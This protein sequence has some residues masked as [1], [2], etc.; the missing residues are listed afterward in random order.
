MRTSF[1]GL[2]GVAASWELLL[3]LGSLY[4][5]DDSAPGHGGLVENIVIAAHKPGTD[6]VIA[7][8]F[9]AHDIH[10]GDHY[11]AIARL[12]MQQG[13]DA[14]PEFEKTPTRLEQ[15]CRSRLSPTTCPQSE[16]ASR[17]GPRI[18]HGT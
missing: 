5:I 1:D 7:R 4:L 15:R 9:F 10:D 17:H 11:W 8:Y 13:P 6:E 18:S 2:R 3:A 12:F 16:V 14:L